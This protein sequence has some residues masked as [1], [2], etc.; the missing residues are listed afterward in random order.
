MKPVNSIDE[1][2]KQIHHRSI[3]DQINNETKQIKRTIQS[4]NTSFE[5]Y[6]IYIF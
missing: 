5:E 1:N 6:I 2:K 4:K 3:I